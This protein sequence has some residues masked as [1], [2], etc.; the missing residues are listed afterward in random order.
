MQEIITNTIEKNKPK[1]EDFVN[2]IR[3]Y[4]KH[5][6]DY[7]WSKINEENRPEIENLVNGFIK[8]FKKYSQADIENFFQEIMFSKEVFLSS[9]VDYNI[10]F[11][12]DYLKYIDKK[13]E[14]NKN[15]EIEKIYDKLLKSIIGSLQSINKQIKAKPFNEDNYFSPESVR[16]RNLLEG[17]ETILYLFDS[18]NNKVGD[19]YFNEENRNIFFQALKNVFP[20]RLGG[21]FQT[22]F[23]NSLLKKISKKEGSNLQKEVFELLNQEL[24]QQIKIAEDKDGSNEDQLR[25][26]RR[27]DE[28]I[29]KACT[30]SELDEG[31]KTKTWE[32]IDILL[33]DCGLST[34]DVF[35]TWF[36]I[37]KHFWEVNIEDHI[38]RIRELEKARPKAAKTLLDEFG[39]SLFK[40]YPLELLIEQY[41]KRNINM[42]YGIYAV[43]HEGVIN[44]EQ[45]FSNPSLL[46]EKG[47]TIRCIEFSN[48]FGFLRKIMELDKRYGGK[49][50]ISFGI[51]SAHGN[52]EGD[53]IFLGGSEIKHVSS[54]DLTPER[55]EYMKNFFTK[56]PKFLFLACN[57]G[58]KD[59]FAESFARMDGAEVVAP[60][61]F[62]NGESN[63]I[64]FEEHDEA[65]C[66]LPAEKYKNMYSVY[67]GE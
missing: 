14:L 54:E 60:H 9:V 31:I 61:E 47:A 2:S 35:D 41:D 46:K 4:N 43:T 33:A 17:G 65:I 24:D 38:K 19:V 42:P 48:S 25:Q 64:F 63:E 18:N 8:E 27:A 20:S 56:N 3:H 28:F 16:N 1:M 58:I 66:P 34:K 44:T 36:N 26:K 7:R 40:K 32:Y 50:K 23:Y 30:L 29:Y 52:I 11:N 21:K 49:N 59:K 39:I 57:L 53:R 67:K 5:L 6:R 13:L 45:H 12:N 10:F 55:I 22:T 51:I 62:V 15:K 37:E